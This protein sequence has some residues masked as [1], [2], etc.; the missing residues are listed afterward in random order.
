MKSKC[1]LAPNDGVSW[2]MLSFSGCCCFHRHSLEPV[3]P[4]VLQQ[5]VFAVAAASYCVSASPHPPPR[6]SVY[7]SAGIVLH[8]LGFYAQ[9]KTHVLTS[10]F[11]YVPIPFNGPSHPYSGLGSTLGLDLPARSDIQCTSE[12]GVPLQ[13]L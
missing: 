12:L 6:K 10:V 5:A 4:E 8:Q 2:Q 7:D 3:F 9:R 1:F 11:M 13:I